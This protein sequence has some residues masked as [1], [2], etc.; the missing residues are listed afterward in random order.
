MLV[1]P[2]LQAVSSHSIRL[3][4]GMRSPAVGRMA[5]SLKR[6]WPRRWRTRI[7]LLLVFLLL[8]PGL[9]LLPFRWLPV[10]QT[11]F[12]VNAKFDA[13][14]DSK[15]RPD[16]ARDWEP[17]TRISPK[18]A[19]AVIAAEDQRFFL[20]SGFDVEAMMK[21]WRH[22]K[23]G[24]RLRGGSTISQQLAKNLF[25]W[26]GRSYLRKGMEAYCTL[27]IELL[28]PKE[29]ILEVY[30][31][32][33]EFGDQTFGAEAAALRF[34]GKPAAKITAREAALMAAVLPSPKRWRV[35]KPSNYV[36]RRAARIQGQMVPLP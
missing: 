7:A 28:W 36:A 25:L 15:A 34:F 24:K 9:L 11:T 16:F 17:M 20:H 10:V 27:W 23:R 14:F 26:S 13:L 31:N 5:A 30:L 35:D 6:L 32:V 4:G 29:R 1:Q 18:L 8:L 33:V 12:M 21:A 19:Q 2:Q 3:R 22:N